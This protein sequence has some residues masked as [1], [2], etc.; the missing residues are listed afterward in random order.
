MMDRL[1]LC[2]EV[3]APWDFAAQ[4][5]YAASSATA[6]WKSRRSRWPTIRWHHRRAGRAMG[7]VAATTA[8]RSAACTGCWWR[9]RACR[10]RR[11]T[12]RCGS[13]RDEAMP[14]LI[15]LCAGSAAATW[16]TARRRSATRA[17][18][19]RG[20]RAGARDGGLGRAPAK[21]RAAGLDYC[22]EPLSR[23]QTS[24][25]NTVA[26]ARPSSPRRRCRACDDARHL[27]RRITEAEPLPALI[28]RGGRAAARARAAQRPQPSRPGA[29]RDRFAPILRRCAPGHRGWIAIEPFD[30][31]PDGPG[32]AAFASATC[33]GCWT[34]PEDGRRSPAVAAA[35]A[36]RAIIDTNDRPPGRRRPR[37]ARG[38]TRPPAPARGATGRRWC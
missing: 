18:P 21:R 38:K 26:E 19:E 6:R 12:R 23:D 9:P 36:P 14:R 24:V 3:L 5:A 4:C 34:R 16:C 11:P 1:A 22:I 27:L 30:Y 37:A 13:A 15:E 28:D 17:R 7:R 10:S 2:N 25:L 33:A 20:R 8:W 32:C 31:R 29:G 35:V